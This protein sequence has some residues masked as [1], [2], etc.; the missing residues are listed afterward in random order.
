MVSDHLEKWSSLG[1]A[2]RGNWGGGTWEGGLGRGQLGRDVLKV[3]IFWIRKKT[4]PKQNKKP[5]L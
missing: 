5:Y 3:V 4:K 1:E 2:R